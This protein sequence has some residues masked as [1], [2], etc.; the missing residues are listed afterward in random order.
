MKRKICCERSPV[1]DRAEHVFFISPTP[2]SMGVYGKVGTAPP[3]AGKNTTPIELRT[4]IE[5]EWGKLSLTIFGSRMSCLTCEKFLMK[6]YINNLLQGTSFFRAVLLPLL[7]ADRT[8]QHDSATSHTQKVPGL[9][10]GRN[11]F[12]SGRKHSFT[13][14]H[15]LL[16]SGLV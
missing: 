5:N 16:F 13:Y 3:E 10:P 8:V 9:K 1:Q 4:A 14:W 7:H 15:S 2:P 12:S 6:F 11:M